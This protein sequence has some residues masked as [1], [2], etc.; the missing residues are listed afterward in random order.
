MKPAWRMLIGKRFIPRLFGVVQF[1][2]WEAVDCI[3][4]E[5]VSRV[6]SNGIIEYED[7]FRSLPARVME[8]LIFLAKNPFYLRRY[9]RLK[10]SIKRSGEAFEKRRTLEDMK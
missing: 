5:C 10:A 3:P 9:F 6:M 8:C 7:R 1:Y 4:R 2:I